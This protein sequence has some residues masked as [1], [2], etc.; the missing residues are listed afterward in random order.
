[1]WIIDQIII[2]SQECRQLSSFT[3]DFLTMKIVQYICI[4]AIG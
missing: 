1:M 4:P 3:E 2:I